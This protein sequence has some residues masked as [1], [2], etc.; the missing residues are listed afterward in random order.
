MTFLKHCFFPAY[1]LFSFVRCFVS[2]IIALAFGLCLCFLSLLLV[3]VFILCFWP[4]PLLL[5]FAFGLCLFMHIASDQPLLLPK[6]QSNRL[7]S[8]NKKSSFI[9]ET[10]NYQSKNDVNPASENVSSKFVLVSRLYGCWETVREFHPASVSTNSY[11]L[12]ILSRKA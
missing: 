11:F 2:L 3:F 9:P 7:W 6:R 4:L 1:S 5:V 12:P 10:A 8:C